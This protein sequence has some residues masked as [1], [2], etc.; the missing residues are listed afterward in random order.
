MGYGELALAGG[1][2]REPRESPVNPFLTTTRTLDL[3]AA[4]R[5]QS[6]KANAPQLEFLHC[7][8]KL[9]QNDCQHIDNLKLPNS[10]GPLV[11]RQR[12]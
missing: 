5:E 7:F 9:R 2:V 10:L 6:E 4:L 12:Q 3:Q 1:R 8:I 11:L